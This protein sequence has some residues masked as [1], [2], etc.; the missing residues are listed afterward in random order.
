MIES[1]LTSRLD[2]VQPISQDTGKDRHHLPI[3]IS[4]SF[5]LAAYLLHGRWQNPAMEWG[6]VA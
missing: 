2:S 5:E 6:S 4:D 1:F 3:A